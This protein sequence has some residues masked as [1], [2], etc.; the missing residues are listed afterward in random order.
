MKEVAVEMR[1]CLIYLGIVAAL[2][3]V[4]VVAASVISVVLKLLLIHGGLDRAT[5]WLV[6]DSVTFGPMALAYAAWF[7]HD[8]LHVWCWSWAALFRPVFVGMSFNFYIAVAVVVR[9]VLDDVL[10]LPPQ[11]ALVSAFCLSVCIASALAAFLLR[12]R[13]FGAHALS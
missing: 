4:G 1:H 13:R 11:L 9:R 8:A 12:Q 10:H 5:A 7:W 3:V 6:A 2:L